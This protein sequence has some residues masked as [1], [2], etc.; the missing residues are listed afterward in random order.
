MFIYVF[1]EHKCWTSQMADR[2][3]SVK[4]Y[5]SWWTKLTKKTLKYFSDF[6]MIRHKNATYLQASMQRRHNITHCVASLIP[7]PIPSFSMFYAEKH[8]GLVSE[9]TCVTLK[10]IKSLVRRCSTTDVALGSP[11]FNAFVLDD[12]YP[13]AP[14]QQR[15]SNTASIKL[16]LWMK[17]DA[18]LSGLGTRRQR[19]MAIVRISC[20]ADMRGTT[21]KWRRP[22]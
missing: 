6:L 14:A 19:R 10:L 8:E 18:V 13:T 22:A 1:G 20:L 5:T 12:I 4:F 21:N 9:V 16:V 15:I 7:K 3:T 17:M 2:I 11:T